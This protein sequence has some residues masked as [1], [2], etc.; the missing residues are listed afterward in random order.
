M[1]TPGHTISARMQQTV[2]WRGSRQ[3]MPEDPAFNL[4]TVALHHACWRRLASAPARGQR[5]IG[6]R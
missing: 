5:A 2:T 3:K 6:T 4:K 1:M